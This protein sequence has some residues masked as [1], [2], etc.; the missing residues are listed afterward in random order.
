MKRRLITRN[1][2]DLQVCW[3]VVLWWSGGRRRLE[4][5]E[6]GADVLGRLVAP[7]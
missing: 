7:V 4:G 6:R 5:W 1:D 3:L 2:S